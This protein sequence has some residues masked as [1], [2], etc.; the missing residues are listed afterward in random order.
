MKKKLFVLLAMLLVVGVAVVFAA[1]GKF[2]AHLTG[3]DFTPPVQTK[4]TGT[5]SVEVEKGEKALEY[6]LHVKDIMDVTGAHIHTGKAGQE[7]PPVLALF[8]GEK[9]GKYSGTLAKGKAT[10]K[11]L[12]GPMQGKTIADLVNEMRAGNAYVNVHTAAHPEGEIRG[13]LKGK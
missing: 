3:K 10:D 2:K 6:R 9:K 12:M 13:E 1:E 5:A 7:G 8:T 4:A 11:D